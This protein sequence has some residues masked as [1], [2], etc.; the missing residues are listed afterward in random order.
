MTTQILIIEDEADLVANLEYNLQ[1]EGYRT[2]SALNGKAGLDLVGHGPTP[3][4]VLLDLMLPDVPGT[5]VCRQIRNH[6]KTKNT[7]VIFLT[8]K[9]DE[10]DRIVGFEIGADDYMTK[11]FSVRELVL[12]IRAV[13]R[14]TQVDE[15]PEGEQIR[16]GRLVIDRGA[17]RAWVGEE[18]VALTALEFRLLTT[19]LSRKGRVQTREKL[20]DDVWGIQADVTTRTVDTHVKRLRQKLGD[21]GAYIETIRG[22]GYRFCTTPDDIKV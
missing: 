3:D 13:L 11:P 15:L 5:E 2:R 9:G 4:L 22:V 18:E 19:F 1:K 12:R 20:L 17:H 21:L 14:R 10:I 16:F 7:P 6:E 8:A